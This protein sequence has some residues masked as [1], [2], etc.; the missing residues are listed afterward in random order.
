LLL[1][2]QQTNKKTTAK[3]CW[4]NVMQIIRITVRIHDGERATIII[5]TTVVIMQRI[6][7]RD[8]YYNS[9][10]YCNGNR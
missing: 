8:L 9:C 10:C 3:T 4:Q 2:T 5:T 6:K 1:L 7:V